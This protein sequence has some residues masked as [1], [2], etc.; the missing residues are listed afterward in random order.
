MLDYMVVNGEIVTPS[1]RGQAN[2]GIKDGRVAVISSSDLELEA[3]DYYDARGK[4]V[5]PALVDTHVHLRDP[6]YSHK[7]DFYTGT[8]AAA[9][10]GYGTVVAQPNTA[11]PAM[12]PASISSVIELGEARS[13][14][15]FAVSAQVAPGNINS[16][17][18]LKEA[19]ALIFDVATCDVPDAWLVLTGKDCWAIFTRAAE[20]GVPVAVYATDASMVGA[21]TKALQDQ[22]R[23]DPLAW[24]ESRP[25]VTEAAEVARLSQ[26]ARGT[27]A[28]I[29]FRQISSAASLDI[30]RSVKASRPLSNISVEVNP[31]HLFLIKEDLE[32]LGPV[33]KMAPPIRD[34]GTVKALWE[35]LCDGTVD[36]IGGDHAPHTWEEKMVGEKD[37]WQAASGVP[38]LETALPL[39][40]DAASRGKITIE[41]I[42]GLM[43]EKPARWL[44]IYPR[45]GTLAVG[46]DADLV[47]IDPDS[48]WE[49]R[50]K[51]LLSKCRWTPFEGLKVKGKVEGTMVRGQWVYERGNIVARPGYGQ[52][53]LCH[54]G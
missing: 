50:G 13:V 28:K 44:N 54:E 26:I 3:A 33:G 20:L 34:S 24:A 47:I 41:K 9:A 12:D 29:M 43:A 46:S 48:S 7:E 35:A 40:L 42:V 4:L 45:K 39:M 23:L 53:V 36:M 10:G 14:V 51:D 27:G 1:W 18:Q 31:H 2:I 16:L 38:T 49:I 11:P 25:P 15:D 22:G 32:R 5:I 52:R 21:F 6:G 37:I 19:G 8:S 17:A 30:L